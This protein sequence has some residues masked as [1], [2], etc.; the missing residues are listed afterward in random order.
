MS[1]SGKYTPL[2]QGSVDYHEEKYSKE[3][4]GERDGDG[5]F[6]HVRY[7]LNHLDISCALGTGRG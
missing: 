7:L 2:I 1:V 3:A 4:G 5:G 6:V